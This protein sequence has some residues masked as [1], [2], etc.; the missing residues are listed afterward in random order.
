[1][2]F[3]FIDQAIVVQVMMEGRGPYSM[4]VDTGT[5]PSAIDIGVARSLVWPVIDLGR[6]GDGGSGGGVNVW[7]LR[8]LRIS[9]F[10][11]GTWRLFIA[12]DLEQVS[13]RFGRK[14]DGILGV[15]ALDKHRVEIDFP[16]R[17]IRFDSMEPS[18]AGT[19]H[20]EFSI[21][22]T[23]P[24][25]DRL[26][27][28]NDVPLRAV[29]DTGFNGGLFL[30]TSGL[31]K[32]GLT[33]DETDCINTTG[34]TGDRKQCFVS[35]DSLQMGPWQLS[36]NRALFAPTNSRQSSLEYDARIGNAL[37]ADFKVIID[38]SENMLEVNKP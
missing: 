26:L 11:G 35:I 4:L 28:I 37:L 18:A 34:Y 9:Q 15:N 21:D 19:W 33:P 2:P 24:G 8:P 29:V 16:G 23:M 25:T 32:L 22:D 1:M 20:S 30:T 7:L 31:L 14:I 5:S 10:P 3:E 17:F 38:Y 36:Q 27:R 6:Q 12:V 13:D